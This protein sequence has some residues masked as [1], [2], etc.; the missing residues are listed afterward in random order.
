MWGLV[1]GNRLPQDRTLPPA[2][3]VA[4]HW[5]LGRMRRTQV[6]AYAS[7]GER[8]LVALGRFLDA[9]VPRQPKRYAFTDRR[10]VQCL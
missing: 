8:L 4:R 1:K 5:A 7:P 10:T 3:E 9:T 6:Y 2:V